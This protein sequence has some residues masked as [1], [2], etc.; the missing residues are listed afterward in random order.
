MND[1]FKKMTPTTAS[2]LLMIICLAVIISPAMIISYAEMTNKTHILQ[3]ESEYVNGTSIGL[4]VVN[5]T[6]LESC[7]GIQTI[8]AESGSYD[9]AFYGYRTTAPS[10][11]KPSVEYMDAYTYIGNNTY[12][13]SFNNSNFE[14]DYINEKL[15]VETDIT[16]GEFAEYDFIRITTDAEIP[17]FIR[18]GLGVDSMIEIEP[19]DTGDDTYLFIPDFNLKS[20]ASSYPN[21]TMYIEFLSNMDMDETEFSM[22]AQGFNFTPADA[23]TWDDEQIY[24]MVIIACDILMIIGF[25]FTTNFIDIKIDNSKPR[26]KNIRKSKR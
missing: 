17:I 5:Q 6:T 16:L 1:Y 18:F 20:S 14:T 11:T 10:Y 13:I 22:N 8:I 26:K 19:I 24:V 9:S 23:P 4:S 12:D 21:A 15:I 3:I 7:Y 2:I 25:I